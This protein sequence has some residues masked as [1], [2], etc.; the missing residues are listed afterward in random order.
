MYWF[1][2]QQETS[3]LRR[4]KLD[5]VYVKFSAQFNELSLFFLKTPKKRLK[6]AKTK[7]VRK[8]Q[9]MTSFGG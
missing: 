1:A 4:Q 5:L 9:Q 3:T 2:L 7:V 8:K 6:M